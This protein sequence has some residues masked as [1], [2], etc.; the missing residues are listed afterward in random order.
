MI[1]INDL[2]M[3][4]KNG[5][6]VRDINLTIN[7]GEVKGL[8]G[9][10]GSG[11]S[12][13]MRSFMGFLLPTSGNMSVNGINTLH[14]SAEAKAVIGYL[15]G[16]P[17]LP[18]NI[19][20]KDLFKLSAKMRRCTIDY[21]IELS[22]RFE[23]DIKQQIK[24]QSKGNR[25]KTALIL[26]LLH[27][28]KALVLD[29]PTSGL[30][31]FHQRTFFETIKSFTDNGASVLLSSHIISEVEKVASSLAV[32]KNGKKIYDETYE[33]FKTNAQSNGKDLE[34]AFFEFYERN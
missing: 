1:Q 9:P 6:G 17:Q 18:Q 3:L 27:K 2:T 26:S 31:P 28:P 21:A 15:P 32:L 25:Q 13:I 20:S 16:D 10:N 7:S 30:D 29:E 22:D 23:L 19:S 8:L 11:K 5:K 14:N 24:E 12:T 34:D 33:V 4:Y